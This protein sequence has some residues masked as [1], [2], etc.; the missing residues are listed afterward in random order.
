M[1]F[2]VGKRLIYLA[3]VG[4]KHVTVYTFHA[5][6]IL[7]GTFVIILMLVEHCSFLL[8]GLL[9]NLSISPFRIY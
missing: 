5:L 8:L 3:W 6:Q 9:Y 4:T 7:T 2:I 1:A